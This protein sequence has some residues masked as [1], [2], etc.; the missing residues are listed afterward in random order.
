MYDFSTVLI[1]LS[2]TGLGL[3]AGLLPGI[4]NVIMLMLTYPF[5]TDFSLFQILLFYVCIT[6]AA[7]YTGSV[8][9]TTLA[10]PGETSSLPAVTEGHRLFL[11]G[12]G[13]FAISNSAIGSFVGSIVTAIIMFIV[14]PYAVTFITKFYNTHVQ[15]TILLLVS[16]FLIFTYAEQK[17][18]VNIGLF[19][20]G[21]TLSMI[22]FSKNLMTYRLDSIINYQE[23]PYLHFGLPLYPVVIALFVFPI[24]CKEWNAKKYDLEL[25][26]KLSESKFFVH[27]KEYIKNIGA[28]LR[29]TIIGSVCGLVPHL[30]A[31][32]ASNVSYIY[33]K[34]RRQKKNVYD[35]DGDLPSLVSAETANNA[36]G[37]TQLTPL[38]L[39]GIPIT[40]SEAIILNVLENNMVVTNWKS[41]IESGIFNQV[42][43]WFVAMN[44][45][46]VIAAWPF[47]KHLHVIFRISQKIL[48]SLTFLVLACLVYYLGNLTQQGWFY[49]LVL[50]AL[51]PLG[52]VLKRYDTLI[53]VFA[54][55]LQK[56]IEAGV[57][58]L[59][60]FYSDI[61]TNVPGAL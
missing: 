9:A 43:I 57:I 31:A 53:V 40:T 42:L 17:I 3:L 46:C 26:S 19:A 22:G 16:L 18:W 60:Y 49:I 4:G 35:K 30:T 47:A 59:F 34:Y 56:Q 5:I 15:V 45:I 54:F 37:L 50:L 33:E 10:V 28:S 6:G 44:L 7:Q 39:I 41:T 32:L 48:Y 27:T 11:K 12:K 38:L 2:G 20:I 51:M 24:F 36:A 21:W 1:L 14:L 25:L 13:N 8:V 52:Y 55:I 23:Y 29:G 58:R 61:F